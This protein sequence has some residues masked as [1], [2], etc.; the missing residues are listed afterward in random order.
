T[1]KLK[2]RASFVGRLNQPSLPVLLDFA[3]VCGVPGLRRWNGHACGRQYLRSAICATR[4]KGPRGPAVGYG[5][6]RTI[7]LTGILSP[8]STAGPR[9]WLAYHT[10]HGGPRLI[11][12]TVRERHPGRL[13]RSRCRAVL[14]EVR[15]L[16]SGDRTAWLGM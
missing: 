3:R 15:T 14:S 1:S 2:A 12:G 8:F 10:G 16:A 11:E 5:P 6:H 13:L 4:S 7:Y 9:G